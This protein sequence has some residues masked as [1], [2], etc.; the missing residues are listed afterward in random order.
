MAEL[1]DWDLKMLGALALRDHAPEKVHR[2]VL[3]RFVVAGLVERIDVKP[4]K[5]NYTKGKFVVRV[6]DTGKKL[7]ADRSA[8]NI[9]AESK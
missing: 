9:S 4:G 1:D 8:G 7:L 3:E 5:P 6:T 2:P